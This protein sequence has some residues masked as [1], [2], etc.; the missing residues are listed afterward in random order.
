MTGTMRLTTDTCGCSI[1]V[2]YDTAEG[3]P[4]RFEFVCPTHAALVPPPAAMELADVVFLYGIIRAE[5]RSKNLAQGAAIDAVSKLR[6][7]TADG[8]VTQADGVEFAWSFTGPPA[9]RQLAVR[10]TGVQLT[11]TEKAS[12]RAG[13]TAARLPLTVTLT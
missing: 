10:F 7:V 12:I 4:L 6:K 11:G 9:R 2:L 1:D 5:Q 3:T 8:E 13:I